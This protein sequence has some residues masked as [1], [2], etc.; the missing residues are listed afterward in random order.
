MTS[1]CEIIWHL[2]IFCQETGSESCGT[3]NLSRKP[4]CVNI[5]KS[6]SYSKFPTKN[7]GIS[8]SLLVT[9]KILEDQEVAYRL[10]LDLNILSLPWKWKLWSA[11]SFDLCCVGEEVRR[12]TFSRD[13]NIFWGSLDTWPLNSVKNR[14]IFKRQLILQLIC[15]SIVRWNL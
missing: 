9:A 13:M 14:S 2:L 3:M 1:P 7:K 12:L 4:I 5:V 15:F 8:W 10:Q 6:P 11:R